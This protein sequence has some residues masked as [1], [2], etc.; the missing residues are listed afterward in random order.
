MNLRRISLALVLAVGA[1]QAQDHQSMMQGM[2][3]ATAAAGRPGDDKL[4]CEQLEEQ[5]VAVVQDPELV[6]HIESAGASAQKQQDAIEKGVKGQVAMQSLR[7]VLMSFIPGGAYGGMASAQSQAMNQGRQ[8]MA[9]MKDKMAQAQKMQALMPK[10]MRGQ[11]VVELA[12]GKQ[13]EWAAGSG[14]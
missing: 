2:Q 8:G 9:S 10:L 14:M 1:V 7:T 12:S 4:T 5:L 13:C 3:E 6:A 11:R